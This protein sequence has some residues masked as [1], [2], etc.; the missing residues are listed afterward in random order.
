[1]CCYRG[2]K[3]LRTAV[4]IVLT[5]QK[6]GPIIQPTKLPMEKKN[7]KAFEVVNESTLFN[8]LGSHC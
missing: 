6:A 3:L 8:L 4:V 1:M 2:S 7:P 5:V